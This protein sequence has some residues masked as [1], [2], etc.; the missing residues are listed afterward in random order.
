MRHLSVGKGGM[1]GQG[2]AGLRE[3]PGW[4]VQD[5]PLVEGPYDARICTRN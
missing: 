1:E 5:A 4:T 3:V 2:A